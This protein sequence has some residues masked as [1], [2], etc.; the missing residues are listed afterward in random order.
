MHTQTFSFSIE[1]ILSLCH[2]KPAARLAFL[3]MKKKRYFL[4]QEMKSAY[5][6]LAWRKPRS[7]DKSMIQLLELKAA[8]NSVGCCFS[9]AICC[10]RWVRRYLTWRVNKP[11]AEVGGLEGSQPFCDSIAC[12]REGAGEQ[13]EGV[14]GSARTPV[15]LVTAGSDAANSMLSCSKALCPAQLLRKSD[16]SLTECKAEQFFITSVVVCVMWFTLLLVWVRYQ[17]RAAT[18]CDSASCKCISKTKT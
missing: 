4:S 1:P 3:D 11:M 2:A 14:G 5:T 12:R 6:Y 9:K 10:I 13:A 15:L 7:P 17:I 16:C 8:E 18:C